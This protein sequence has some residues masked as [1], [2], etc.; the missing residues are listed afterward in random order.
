MPGCKCSGQTCS[1]SIVNGVGT[2]VTGTGTAADP[3]K[4]NV[5][6]SSLLL[7]SIIKVSDSTTL[8][9]TQTGSG[10]VNDPIIISGRVLL[11]SPSGSKYTLAVSNAG[12]LSAIAT[13]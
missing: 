1:C 4:L 2:V 8:D 11:Y 12:V 13:T 9:L 3:F 6:P 7:S 5:D 10:S